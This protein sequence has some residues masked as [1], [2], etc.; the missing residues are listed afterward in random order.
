MDISE[1]EIGDSKYFLSESNLSI[2]KDITSLD[3]ISIYPSSLIIKTKNKHEK[4][5]KVLADSIH[6]SFKEGYTAVGELIIEPQTVK[7]F[8]PKEDLKLIKYLQ[9]GEKSW[10][11]LDE[12]IVVKMPL[13]HLKKDYITFSP[14]IVTITQKV[15]RVQTRKISNL[16]VIISNLPHK[17][18]AQIIPNNATVVFSGP[19]SYINRL[20]INNI[21]VE[22][23]GKKLKEGR[24]SVIAQIKFPEENI[25]LL[26]VNPP[27]FEVIIER[28]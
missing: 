11:N 22:I 27:K 2:P 7:I 16:S 9:I 23:D 13:P 5:V 17:Y 15:E 19:I 14:E 20:S 18:N 8:G 10:K 21:S 3:V 6:T 12:T 24:H 26:E 25:T 28:K 1:I 4:E